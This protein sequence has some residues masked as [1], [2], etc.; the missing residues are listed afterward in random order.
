MSQTLNKVKTD[1]IYNTAQILV[2]LDLAVT[3]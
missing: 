1:T 2:L 3:L